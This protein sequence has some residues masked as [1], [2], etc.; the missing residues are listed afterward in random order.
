MRRLSS[1]AALLVA[2]LVAV[3]GCG[4]D[5]NGG[6]TDPPPASTVSEVFSGTLTLNGARTHT[7]TVTATGSIVA[8]LTDLKMQNPANTD[9]VIPVGVSLGTWNGSICQIVLDNPATKQGDIVPG[10]TTATGD[11]C[12]RVYDPLGTIVQPQAYTIEVTYQVSPS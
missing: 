3:N 6:P 12:V 4:G 7:F 5:D 8:Q 11:F 1:R 2:L 9:P 10:Q